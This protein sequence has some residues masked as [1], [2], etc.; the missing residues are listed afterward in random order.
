MNIPQAQ[1]I[2]HELADYL[3]SDSLAKGFSLSFDSRKHQVVVE[4]N[5]D[6]LAKIYLLDSSMVRKH[7]AFGKFR[8]PFFTGTHPC[9]SGS[10]GLFS[11]GSPT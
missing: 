11:S 4:D 3:I 5:Q 8:L 6:W 7:R 10:C 9:R 1:L 2:S